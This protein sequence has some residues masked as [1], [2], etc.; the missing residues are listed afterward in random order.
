MHILGA[1]T[2]RRLLSRGH[3]PPATE[4]ALP[5]LAPPWQPRC[6][7]PPNSEAALREWQLLQAE[8]SEPSGYFFSENLVSNELGYLEAIRALEQLPSNSVFLGV[9][10]EQNLSYLGALDCPLAFIVDI[11]KD[12]ARLHWLYR[13]LFEEARSRTEWLA[14]L[15][16]RPHHPSTDPGSAAP[17][18]AV[19]AQ[20]TAEQPTEASFQGAHGR[21]RAQFGALLP[22]LQRGDLKRIEGI[23]R[24]FWKR[25]LD[26]TF[27]LE[28]IRLRRYPSLCDLLCARSAEGE[29]AG[30]L[31]SEAHFRAVQALERN[32]R[33]VPVV[34]DFAGPKTL[35]ALGRTLAL[36]QLKFGALY[37]SNVEQYLFEMGAWKPW[38]TNLERLPCHPEAVVIR[39]FFSNQDG[40]VP[41]APATV[42]AQLHRSLTVA[43]ETYLSNS[44]LP[45]HG[46][47]TVVHR[48]RPF[49]DCAR[50]GKYQGFRDVVCDRSIRW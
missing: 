1:R 19:L 38:L 43:A 6:S 49:L 17:I 50:Q 26:L 47:T 45:V 2:L 40:P 7:P 29:T 33:V 31:A 14:L 30:F 28:G 20:A 3:R 42:L 32:S 48:L 25:Q 18:E 37:L 36:R 23:H 16:G 5:C 46:M 13:A 12:N 9:G 4:T 39:S 15:L 41:D 44:P 21:L 11:R 10:P 34:G 24:W 8:L 22:E 27:Q 35:A